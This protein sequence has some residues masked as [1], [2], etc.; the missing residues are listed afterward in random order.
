MSL[1]HA[2]GTTG[3]ITTFVPAGTLLDHP[4]AGQLARVVAREHEV[5]V[6]REHEPLRAQQHAGRAPRPTPG[7]GARRRASAH[8]ASVTAP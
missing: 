6:D 1:A 3:S 7:A 4:V 8:A 2:S 5:V